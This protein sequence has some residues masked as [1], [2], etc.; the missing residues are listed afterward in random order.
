MFDKFRNKDGTINGASAMAEL[1][2]LSQEEITWSFKRLKQLMHN[3]GLSK[4]EAL[5][6][7][8]EESKNKPWA[9]K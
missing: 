3:D 5:A 4:K 9:Q 7:V 8:K 1:T 2:G 6:V